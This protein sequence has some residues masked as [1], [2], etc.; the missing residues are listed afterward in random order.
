[1]H[2]H[3]TIF[4]HHVLEQF[5]MLLIQTNPTSTSSHNW[6]Y[7]SK[8]ISRWGFTLFLSSS[9]H[10]WKFSIIKFSKWSVHTIYSFM[11][12]CIPWEPASQQTPQQVNAQQCCPCGAHTWEHSIRRQINF[13]GIWEH[14][15]KART[16][17]VPEPSYCFLYTSSLLNEC[18]PKFLPICITYFLL[19]RTHAKKSE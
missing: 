6:K 11:S 3:L 5:K 12:A 1:M 7:W 16:V 4:N 17:W 8:E 14:Q 19:L 10:I 2:V 13:L 15:V 9:M 18:N